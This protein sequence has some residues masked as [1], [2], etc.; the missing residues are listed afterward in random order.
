MPFNNEEDGDEDT[1][2]IFH[3]VVGGVDDGHDDGDDEPGFDG[4][5]YRSDYASGSGGSPGPS[6]PRPK[7][8]GDETGGGCSDI[9]RG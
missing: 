5:S 6:R 8:K 2:G 1:S 4:Q 9:S 3:Q 7:P